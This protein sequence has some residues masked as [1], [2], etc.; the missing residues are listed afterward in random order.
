MCDGHY[1]IRRSE[2]DGTDAEFFNHLK[3]DDEVVSAEFE[4]YALPRIRLFNPVGDRRDYFLRTVGENQ[5]AAELN[6]QRRLQ[7]QNQ[8]VMQSEGDDKDV[9]SPLY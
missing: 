9:D 3:S 5:R 7:R 8:S 6:R 4:K 1:Q 2:F